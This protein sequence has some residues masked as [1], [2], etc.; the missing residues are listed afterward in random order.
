MRCF[1]QVTCHPLATSTVRGRAS[2]PE[3]TLASVHCRRRKIRCVLPEDE[4]QQRCINCIRLKKECIFYPVDQ[5]TALDAQ[6]ESSSKTR[7]PSTASST[8]SSS[9]PHSSTRILGPHGQQNGSHSNLHL[10]VQSG[11]RGVPIA[12]SISPTASASLNPIVPPHDQY[13]HDHHGPSRLA[14][15]PQQG[16]ALQSWQLPVVNAMGMQPPYATYNNPALQADTAPF[17]GPADIY[18]PHPPYGDSGM[19]N[20]PPAPTPQQWHQHQ[21]QEQPTFYPQY[22]QQGVFHPTIQ[23][24]QQPLGFHAQRLEPQLVALPAGHALPPVQHSQH[25]MQHSGQGS[26][27]PAAPYLPTQQAPNHWHP[28]H[29]HPAFDPADHGTHARHPGPDNHSAGRR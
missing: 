10:E 2:E 13:G 17:P 5:Q 24:A 21:Q 23:Q 14:Y 16:H 26:R 6:S 25:M 20:H 15:P 18:Q 7:V 27:L 19:Y 22:Q 11:L 9:P 8:V 28:G 29:G 12:P 1:C 3:L 4:S